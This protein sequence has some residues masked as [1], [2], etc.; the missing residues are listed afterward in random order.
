MKIDSLGKTLMLGKI[1]GRRR[2]VWQRMRWLDS[3][4]NS[5]DVS[6]SNLWGMVK[7]RGAWCVA[8]QE[9]TKRW[10][11]LV[12]EQKQTRQVPWETPAQA[13]TWKCHLH[14]LSTSHVSVSKAPVRL[15]F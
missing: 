2:R 10:T 14:P 13:Y 5:M 9:V 7:D 15:Y 12:T 1:E 6:Q 4:T 11:R 3:I 8:V